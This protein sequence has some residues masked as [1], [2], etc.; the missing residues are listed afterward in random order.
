[1]SDAARASAPRAAER[2]IADSATSMLARASSRTR[3]ATATR[4]NAASAMPREAEAWNRPLVRLR[5]RYGTA[6]PARNPPRT[7]SPGTWTSLSVIEWLPDARM[8]SASQS[9]LIVTPGVS[10]ALA[11]RGGD[12]RAVAH[13]A[14]Q[15]LGERLSAAGLAGRDGDLHPPREGHDRD[16]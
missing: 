11:L 6:S 5:S 3:S 9:P 1:M 15:R 13:D 7:A 12:H 14:S 8:P 2:S 4:A 16:Q 10:A